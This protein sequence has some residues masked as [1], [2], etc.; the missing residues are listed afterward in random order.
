M[1]VVQHLPVLVLYERL[2]FPNQL[3]LQMQLVRY[4]LFFNIVAKSF[5]TLLNDGTSTE[6]S[7][8]VPARL[9]GFSN[10]L[11][12]AAAEAWSGGFDDGCRPSCRSSFLAESHFRPFL[13]R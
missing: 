2:D 5:R 4:P 13:G 12:P 11:F 3:A 6:K 1:F 10:Q 7:V 8:N 9:V